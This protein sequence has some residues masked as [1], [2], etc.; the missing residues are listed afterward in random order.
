[1]GVGRLYLEQSLRRMKKREKRK[2][3][4]EDGERATDHTC[5][6]CFRETY[7]RDGDF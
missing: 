7:R 3:K 5:S 1:M 6:A 2:Q 4:M